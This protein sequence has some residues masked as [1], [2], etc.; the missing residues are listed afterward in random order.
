MTQHQQI[1]AYMNDHGT[2]TPMQ[3]FRD[4][5]I[6]KLATRISE[7]KRRG[8][9]IETAYIDSENDQGNHYRYAMY[10]LGGKR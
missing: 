2:I 9:D 6:T 1:I 3:A 5:K 7:L 4:L 8:V 10:R